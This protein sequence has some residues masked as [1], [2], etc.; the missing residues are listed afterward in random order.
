[1]SKENTQFLNKLEEWQREATTI[2]RGSRLEARESYEYLRGNQLPDEVLFE[3]SQRGQPISWENAYQE[4]DSKIEGL[5]L[6]GQQEVKAVPRRVLNRQR[7]QIIND[8]LK[9]FRDS[10]E[11]ATNKKLS[12]RDLRLSGVTA[13]EVKLKVVKGEVDAL[14]KPL[15]EV[16][17]VYRPSLELLFDPYAQRP[18]FSDARFVTHTRLVHAASLPKLKW[19]SEQMVRLNRTWYRDEKGNIRL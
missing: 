18:D 2:H 10:T 13:M 8:T 1:M 19:Q 3:L 15:H 12:N 16:E 4:I 6:L 17:Y 11:Y 7:V 5:T 9:S 14:G